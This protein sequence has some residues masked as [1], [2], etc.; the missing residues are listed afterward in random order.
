MLDKSSKELDSGEQDSFESGLNCNKECAIE[1]CLGEEGNELVFECKD[2]EEILKEHKKLTAKEVATVGF[3]IGP[4]W[5]AT[6]VR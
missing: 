5:F 4:I 2:N 6:E 3:C 1:I